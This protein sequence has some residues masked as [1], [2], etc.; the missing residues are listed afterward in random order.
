ME[1]VIYVKVPEKSKARVLAAMI[2]EP[3]GQAYPHRNN[4]H[5]Q[6]SEV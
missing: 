2:L 1:V 4:P 5:T 6:L 3:Y